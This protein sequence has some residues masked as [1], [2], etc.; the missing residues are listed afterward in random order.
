MITEDM[1]ISELLDKY[2]EIEKVLEKYNLLCAFCS[3]AETESVSEAAQAHDV[4]LKLLL[5]DLNEAI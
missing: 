3:A 4:N 2:P 5:K 1:N